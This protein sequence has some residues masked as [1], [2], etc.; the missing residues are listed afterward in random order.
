MMIPV[1]SKRSVPGGDARNLVRGHVRSPNLLLE[2]IDTS[3]T[4]TKES[5]RD[6][7]GSCRGH[8]QTMIESV[9]KKLWR[10]ERKHVGKGNNLLSLSRRDPFPFFV[11]LVVH[12]K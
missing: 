2:G 10:H 6:P 9:K 7:D 1:M 5:S 8:C 3:A 4:A 12:K 11:T